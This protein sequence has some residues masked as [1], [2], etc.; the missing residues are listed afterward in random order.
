MNLDRILATLTLAVIVY[1]LIAGPV[2]LASAVGAD[3]EVWCLS[4][5]KRSQVVSTAATL[6][7][8]KPAGSGRA[9]IVPR[10][11]SEKLNLDEWQ[12]ARP[13][14]FAES[15]E[16]AYE[17]FGGGGAPDE[18][19]P[20]AKVGIAAL[21]GG[22]VAGVGGL[23]SYKAAKRG[24]DDEHGF[25]RSVSRSKRLMEDLGALSEAVDRLTQKKT[26]GTDDATDSQK[27]RSCATRL[28]STIRSS[29]L[30]GDAAIKSLEKV[31]DEIEA[32][33][34]ENR[35]V[36]ALRLALAGAEAETEVQA[37]IREL[38]T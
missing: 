32:T 14:D 28:E 29:G 13:Q 19:S 33:D 30:E 6:G 10:G 9:L 18:E 1:S 34:D 12:Q 20:A 5:G 16:Q 31:K 36:N 8:G 17:V 23:I 2:A 21:A 35:R 4:P 15:C 25:Q 11:S 27:A 37:L 38:G 24:R 7:L 26:E 22:A 3:E